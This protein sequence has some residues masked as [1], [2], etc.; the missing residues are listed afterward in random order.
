[1]DEPRVRI[2][3]KQDQVLRE[4]SQEIRD[5]VEKR[6]PELGD[7][8]DNQKQAMVA[9]M[10]I[11]AAVIFYLHWRDDVMPTMPAEKRNWFHRLLDH[12]IDHLDQ[13]MAEHQR[14]TLAGEAEATVFP[15]RKIFN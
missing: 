10:M 2:S 11:S 7:P 8:Y 1:V 4:L 3:P 15:D 13:Q 12:N 5:L 9:S 6:L 14:Q